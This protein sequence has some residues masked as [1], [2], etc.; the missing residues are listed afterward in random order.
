MSEIE[1]SSGKEPVAEA[2]AQVLA[3]D[4]NA[5][6]IIYK[7][8]DARLRAFVAARHNRRGPDFVDEVAARTHVW[9]FRHLGGYDAARGASFQTWLNL[10][11]RNEAQAVAIE[12]YG[13]RFERLDE[14]RHAPV[15]DVVPDPA[16]V[17]AR[18][19][20][21]RELWREY[22]ALAEEGRLSVALH[23]I[24]G[25]SFPAIARH[26][27]MTVSKV[28]RMREGALWKLR[29]RLRRLGIGARNCTVPGPPAWSGRNDTGYDDDWAASVTAVLP[30]GPDELVGVGAEPVPVDEEP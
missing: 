8:C 25:R 13:R 14:I 12:R 1:G 7:C 24:D 19:E 2:I 5:Y 4:E 20:S 10:Q 26:M 30:D 18:D 6:E 23:D 22:E 28:R 21:A 17:R 16:D 15:L 29:R 9:A 11:S 3:G 27:S